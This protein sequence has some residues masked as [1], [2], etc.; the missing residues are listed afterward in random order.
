[1]IIITERQKEYLKSYIENIDD[2]IEKDDIQLL[3]DTIDDEIVDNILG[4]NDEP[5]EKGIE[6][7]KIYDQIYNQN[8]QS[9]F[10]VKFKGAFIVPK[11]GGRLWNIRIIEDVKHT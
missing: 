10:E 5:D 2:L 11:T 8:W 4:N 7:Q 3:L 6:L 1:M 9:T